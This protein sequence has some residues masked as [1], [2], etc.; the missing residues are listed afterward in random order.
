VI[1]R[2]HRANPARRSRRGLT[3][4]ECVLASALLGMVA[5]G[6]LGMI[7][8]IWGWQGRQQQTLGAAEL[9]NRLILTYLD[10]STEM[11]SQFLPLEY[12]PYRYRWKMKEEGVKVRDPE[13]L[14]PEVA[15]K[16]AEKSQRSGLDRIK[17]VSV[18]VWLSEE[19]G[20]AMEP[21]AG[22]PQATLERLVDPLAFRNP[23]SIKKKFMHPEKLSEML[24][25]IA[26]GEQGGDGQTEKKKDKLNP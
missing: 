17:F 25:D 10:D 7:S 18:H 14:P 19:T 4:L 12:G 15:Q 13:D 6:F 16:R 11:P 9:A 21:E 24:G 20:G 2:T 26:R 3:L 1:V 22:T 5:A 23:D 8:A